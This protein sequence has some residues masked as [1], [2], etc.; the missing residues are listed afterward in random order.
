[1]RPRHATLDRGA[2]GSAPTAAV[3]LA[4]VIRL[5]A[6]VLLLGTVLLVVALVDQTVA[7]SAATPQAA[8]GPLTAAPPAAAPQRTLDLAPVATSGGEQG[9]RPADVQRWARALADG[10]RV[11]SQDRP[12]PAP[13]RQA[14]TDPPASGLA[15]SLDEPGAS[16]PESPPPSYQLLWTGS[17]PRVER[18]RRRSH[19]GGGGGTDDEAGTPAGGAR[20]A[21]GW[22]QRATTAALPTAAAGPWTVRPVVLPNRQVVSLTTRR[23]PGGGVEF[24]G[25][26]PVGKP[27]TRPDGTQVYPLFQISKYNVVALETRVKSGVV[28]IAVPQPPAPEPGSWLEPRRIQAPSGVLFLPV[29]RRVSPTGRV[30]FEG[31]GPIGNPRNAA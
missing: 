18:G 24:E 17:D 3:A 20:L 31:A 22:E 25:S 4:G 19:P 2:A 16:E 12:R 8:G 13:G 1:V 9:A 26:R 23:T 21:A 27:E 11:L 28:E 29:D 5:L 6:A 14:A 10:Q 7:A 30:T 15:P